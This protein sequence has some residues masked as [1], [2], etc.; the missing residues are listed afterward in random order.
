MLTCAPSGVV[1]IVTFFREP[2]T[3]E[4]QPLNKH[5]AATQMKVNGLVF[6]DEILLLQLAALALAEQLD[7]F[8]NSIAGFGFAH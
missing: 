4:A 5:K 2:L 6:I 1:S 8:G 7:G 3:M